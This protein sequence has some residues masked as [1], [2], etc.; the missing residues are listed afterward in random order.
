MLVQYGTEWY[1]MEMI[2]TVSRSLVLYHYYSML[3]TVDLA[4]VLCYTT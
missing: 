2:E 1:S 3:R 4:S